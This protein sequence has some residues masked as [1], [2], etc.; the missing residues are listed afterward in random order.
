MIE[1]S[2]IPAA[3]LRVFNLDLI[4]DAEGVIAILMDYLL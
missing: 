2:P 4:G 3:K 1:S